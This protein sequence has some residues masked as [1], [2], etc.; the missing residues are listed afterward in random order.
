MSEESAVPVTPEAIA[1]HLL[2][3]FQNNQGKLDASRDMDV[4]FKAGLASYLRD[5]EDKNPALA[6]VGVRLFRCLHD[7]H[8]LLLMCLAKIDYL[9][10]SLC[11]AIET[12]NPIALASGARALLEHVGSL[13]FVAGTFDRLANS[14]N[15]QQSE[16]KIIS[17]IESASGFFQR[18][19]YGAGSK[20]PNGKN[21]TAPHVESDYIKTLEKRCGDRFENIAQI[22]GKLCEFVHP[23]YGSNLLV[24][25]GEI[26]SGKIKPPAEVL[27]PQTDEFCTQ[28]VSFCA[29]L[30]DLVGDICFRASA[31]GG[32][33]RSMSLPG[34]KLQNIFSE[35]PAI[36]QGDGL[37]EESAFY[38]HNAR[39]REES[40][41][42]TNRFLSEKGVPPNCRRAIGSVS[43]EF[44]TEYWETKS[45]K[46][47]FRYI[48]PMKYLCQK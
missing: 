37:S 31:L 4:I 35:R 5:L 38:F 32:V 28:I 30:D 2:R 46:I 42:M 21:V 39:T 8:F 48:N 13:A 11:H 3:R 15:G 43:E 25:G 16:P 45:G 12:K 1:L 44:L 26:G 40:M 14:L 34:A 36:P 47:W 9:A 20:N 19:Y 18:C 33:L 27:K 17:S 41:E 7:G 6:S 24:S 10:S 29:M 22:Y 23:N